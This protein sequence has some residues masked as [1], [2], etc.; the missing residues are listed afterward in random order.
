MQR[1]STTYSFPLPELII[2]R[3]LGTSIVT[4]AVGAIQEDFHVST[5]VAILPLSLYV[6][7]LGFG[8]IIAAPLSE[9][10]GR[11]YVYVL[12][13]PI[14]ALF[15]LGS[16]FSQN[17]WTLCILRFFAGLA[18]SPCLAIGGGTLA[19]VMK[20]EERSTPT[21]FYIL[22]PFLGPALG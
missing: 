2:S 7:A 6:L 15:T 13:T 22:S 12:S 9:T 11:Y 4:P 1:A 5:T 16:G 21:S 8:P 19:D 10:Y 14:A 18:F 20:A 3:S 17:I